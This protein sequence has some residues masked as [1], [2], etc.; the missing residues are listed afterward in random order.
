[1]AVQKLRRRNSARLLLAFIASKRREL[2]RDVVQV[3]GH[4]GTTGTTR[5]RQWRQRGRR[6]RWQH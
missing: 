1:M 2:L 3:N 5:D 4:R 6:R